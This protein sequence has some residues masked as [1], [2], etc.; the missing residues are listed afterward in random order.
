MAQTIDR[1]HKSRPGPDDKPCTEHRSTT[2]RLV[3]SAAH[4]RGLRW[5]VRYRDAQGE[6]RAENFEKKVDAYSRAAEIKSDL[7]K[8]QLVDRAAGRRTFRELAEEWRKGAIHRERT[9]SRVE[10]T[11][12]LH[13]YPT[14]GERG[15]ASIKRS[16]VQSWV[17]R[18]SQS[19]E[20]STVVGHF[21]VL[22]TVMRVAVLDGVIRGNPCD[23]VTLPEVR[24]TVIVPEALAVWALIEAAP[25]RYK[26]LVRLAASSGLRQG[27]L[28]GLEEGSGFDFLR[29]KVEVSHQLCTPGKGPQ[30]LGSLKTPESYRDVPLASSAVTEMSVHVAKFPPVEVE[31][32]D[33]TDPLKPR[34]RKARLLFTDDRGRPMRRSTWSRIWKKIKEDAAKLLNDHFAELSLQWRRLGQ[35]EG[36]E[37]ERMRVPEKCTLHGLRD[38]YATVLIK[39][40]ESVKTVQV[41]LGHSKPSITLDKYVGF[42]P[43]DEDTTAAA[44]ESVLGQLGQLPEQQSARVVHGVVGTRLLPPA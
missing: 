22:C 30:Y 17:K 26:A 23:G 34:T 12:R 14:F 5:Q 25:P 1:W 16:D 39:K 28:F 15:I 3:P 7:D 43:T 27:E 20:A 35:P 2:R 10:G 18:Q 24:R 33:R 32:E 38:F 4:G 13:L 37:P 44:I 21:E 19:Y 6:Q 31:I 41:R 29:R 8:G 36:R 11:L 40:R 9:E 42:W